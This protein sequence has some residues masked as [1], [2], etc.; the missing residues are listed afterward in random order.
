MYLLLTI[1][2]IQPSAL[3][4]SIFFHAALI[5]CIIAVLVYFLGVRA[6]NIGGKSSSGAQNSGSRA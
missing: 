2:I 3:Y 5:F 6:L 1:I 4:G